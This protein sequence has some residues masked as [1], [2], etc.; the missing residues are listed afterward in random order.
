MNKEIKKGLLD[1]CVLKLLEEKESYGY[2]VTADMRELID[3]SDSSLYPVLR[4]LEQSGCLTTYHRPYNGR[5]RKYYEITP[6]GLR[7]LAEMRRDWQ[8]V[9]AVVQHIM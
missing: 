7:C 6:A 3:V 9:I 8:E 1:A 4:R 2:A 5:M